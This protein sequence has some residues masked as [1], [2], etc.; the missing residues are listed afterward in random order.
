[1]LIYVH[2]DVLNSLMYTVQDNNIIAVYKLIL[3][4]NEVFYSAI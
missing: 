1:M 4:F 2:Y 3:V